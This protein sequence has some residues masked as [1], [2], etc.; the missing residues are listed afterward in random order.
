MSRQRVTR[1]LIPKPIQRTPT[2]R[3]IESPRL[4][5]RG[6]D[7]ITER[8][9]A[10]LRNATWLNDEPLNFFF[11]HCIKDETR[12]I[13][14]F[15]SGFF[16][17]L[18]RGGEFNLQNYEEISRWGDAHGLRSLTQ[19]LVPINIA[20]THWIFLR[21]L[22]EQ[23]CIE[24][25]DSNG[26]RIPSNRQYM[27]DMRKYLHLEL[28]KHLPADE[29][30][31]YEV[32]KRT[33]RYKDRSTR[34]PQQ[35]NTDDCGVFVIVSAYLISRGI[36][37]TRE[38][39]NQRAIY[40][41][42]VRVALAHIILSMSQTSEERTAFI[43]QLGATRRRRRAAA[44]EAAN[45]SRRRRKKDSRIVPSGQGQIAALVAA[46]AE[47]SP[48]TNPSNKRYATLLA[49]ETGHGAQVSDFFLPP[50]KKRKKRERG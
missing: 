46:R 50:A 18:Y 19:L 23:K 22:F 6:N 38:T 17:M 5:V 29:R 12:K 7:S 10:T 32:W 28:N 49:E 26:R 40:S 30:P 43:A 25:Y 8:T 9:F 27:E 4:V 11:K 34:T 3:I 48:S 16:T 14:C 36:E 44:A 45:S 47:A 1:A 20:N 31:L 33:W 37:L 15:T 21:V 13:G 2:G 42:K 24:L 41:R 35:E 39:Y